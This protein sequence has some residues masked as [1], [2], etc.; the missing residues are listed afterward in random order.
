[1]V[2]IRKLLQLSV[3]PT[4]TRF[5]TG[6]TV[7][8]QEALYQPFLPYQISAKKQ[9]IFK[10]KQILSFNLLLAGFDFAVLRMC[11]C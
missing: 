7:V 1:M 5:S 6:L 11:V 4:L 8:S 9:W 2:S 10:A 3:L